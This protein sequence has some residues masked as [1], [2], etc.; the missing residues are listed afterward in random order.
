MS[1]LVKIATYTDAHGNKRDCVADIKQFEIKAEIRDNGN[2]TFSVFGLKEER[3]EIKALLDM[4][5]VEELCI[6]S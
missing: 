3:D 5:C 2:G 6:T 1:A 4:T